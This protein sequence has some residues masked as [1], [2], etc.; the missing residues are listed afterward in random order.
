LPTDSR[1]RGRAGELLLCLGGWNELTR[2]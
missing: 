2:A 1:R